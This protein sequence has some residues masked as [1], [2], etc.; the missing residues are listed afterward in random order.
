MENLKI[1]PIEHGE[2]N[3]INNVAVIGEQ[4]LLKLLRNYKNVSSNFIQAADILQLHICLH[5][6]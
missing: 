3:C 4:D 2:V 5:H 1:S 6:K